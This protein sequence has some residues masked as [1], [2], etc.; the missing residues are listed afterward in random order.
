MG[1]EI[2]RLTNANI[3][4]DGNSWLGRAEEVTLPVITSKMSEHKALGMV[5][6][7][8]LF[9]GIDK[10]EARIKWNS[11]YKDV[12]KKAANPTKT[13]QMQVRASLENYGSE[14]K[15]GES[16]CVV[17]MTAQF[18]ALPL[19][20]FKQNENVELESALNV[21]YIKLVVGGETILELDVLANIYTV[22]G[23]D[24]LATYRA[25]LGI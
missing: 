20:T 14:G 17:Y 11:V 13:V 25:N 1:L 2:N 16:A 5:G 22:D 7:V 3:Y 19:G 15:T 8:E 21:T 12:F 4:V 10:L 24:L 23:V 9:S 6:M 18:K